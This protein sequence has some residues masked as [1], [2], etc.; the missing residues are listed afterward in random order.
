MYQNALESYNNKNYSQ[1][2]NLF[3]VFI[4]QADQDNRNL[5]EAVFYLGRIYEEQKNY[6]LALEYYQT[7]ISSYYGHGKISD[8]L[9]ALGKTYYQ[10]KQYPNAVAVFQKLY[11]DFPTTYQAVEAIYLE[12]QTLI[13]QKKLNEAEL[14]INRLVKKYPR[15]F[16]A[17]DSLSILAKAWLEI[18][19]FPQARKTLKRLLK[20]DSSESAAAAYY[21]LGWASY[22]EGVTADNREET[23]D[24]LDQIVINYPE[25]PYAPKSIFL[26]AQIAKEQSLNL[27]AIQKYRQLIDDYPAS[28]QRAESL[29]NL[30]RIYREINQPR[31]A[32]KVLKKLINAYPDSKFT[33][34]AYFI[35]G[36]NAQK[37]GDYPTA[38]ASY[39]N[40]IS[41]ASDQHNE[42]AGVNWKPFFSLASENY[43]KSVQQL[44]DLD[45][46]IDSYFMLAESN[47]KMGNDNA[48][49][50]Y[51]L[52]AIQKLPPG[53]KLVYKAY[54]GQASIYRHK[55]NWRKARQIYQKLLAESPDEKMKIRL[56]NYLAQTS[57]L[58]GDTESA[59]RLLNDIIERYPD[60]IETSLSYYW[61]GQIFYQKKL[62][63]EAIRN[64]KLS[65]KSKEQKEFVFPEVLYKL[66]YCYYLT[67]DNIDAVLTLEKLVTRFPNA[68]ESE[69]ACFLLANIHYE[70]GNY[71]EAAR[72]Y[73]N[74]PV[75]Y[76]DTPIAPLAQY[77]LAVI[78]FK[79]NK[80]T[81]AGMEFNQFM[82]SFPG[83]RLIETV[84]F[85][86]GFS[87]FL[88]EDWYGVRTVLKN[89]TDKFKKTGLAEEALYLLFLEA[90]KSGDIPLAIKYLKRI[91]NDF[92]E[93]PYQFEIKISQ[94]DFQVENSLEIL[95]ELKT[96]RFKS[97]AA[98]V[99]QENSLSVINSLQPFSE[100]TKTTISQLRQKHLQKLR[101]LIINAPL[102]ESE[103]Y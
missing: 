40:I 37:D 102:R 19:A 6:L 22:R 82:V 93:N 65:L 48:A 64:F 45:F 17:K 10:L 79:N 98:H 11:S 100:V 96:G 38:I 91:E 31:T 88:G 80:F 14:V 20:L 41:Q 24:Y 99:F 15:H 90:Q 3:K 8:V 72:Y 77:R 2:I 84:N 9:L 103:Y 95:D 52:L 18:G 74:I 75:V 47:L 53:D 16:L 49:L 46:A 25:S 68:N 7:F 94:A 1:S 62:Y 78:H 89:F 70:L 29:F 56:S 54:L 28:E 71:F 32:V 23:F 26:K 36:Q 43:L 76:P 21:G 12:S 67:K 13:A 60:Y 55:N 35:I 97:E 92:P 42:P 69:R 86:L 39:I 63:Q 66:G 61:R 83:H 73:R 30:A 81:E 87:H 58:A 27:L 57:F 50:Q 59:L 34:N 5:P 44:N 85:A 33:P 4:K 51:Y 101:D